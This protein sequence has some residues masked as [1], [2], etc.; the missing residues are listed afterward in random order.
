MCPPVNSDDPSAH[1]AE[2]VIVPIS[3]GI[4]LLREEI[5]AIRSAQSRTSP[6]H[7]TVRGK[8]RGRLSVA[9]TRLARR[10]TPRLRPSPSRRSMTAQRNVD[11]EEHANSHMF[12]QRLIVRR[13]QPTSPCPTA[14]HFIGASDETVPVG[15]SAPR[16]GGY[17]R[18]QVCSSLSSKPARP[19]PTA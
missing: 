19:S 13:R 10:N 14:D 12:I 18:A 7:R 11:C 9:G 5:R 3:H 4:G 2:L 16:N 17:P 15:H 8:A 1:C 6:R